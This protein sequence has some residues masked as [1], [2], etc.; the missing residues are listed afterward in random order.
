M[1]NASPNA[2]ACWLPASL[3][4]IGVGAGAGVGTVS[5]PAHAADYY[6]GKTIDIIV[7]NYPGGGYDIY[8]RTVARHLG[9]N[10]PG[11]PTI[12]VKNMPGAG[13]AK[14]GH[15]VGTVAPKD[16]LSIGAV[17]PGAI[18]GPLLDD[19]PDSIFEP[20]KVTYLGTA[21][22]GTRICATFEKS[23]T[24]TFQQAMTQKTVFGGVAAGDAIH[25]FAYMVKKTTGAAINVVAGYKGTLD[26]TLAMERGEI[27]GAC[28]WDWSSAKSQK[29]DWLRDGKL[30]LLLQIGPSANPELTKLGVPEL[31]G[32]I[33]D[34]DNRKV[35][36]TIVSQQAF[37][38]PYFIAQGTPQEY[39]TILRT[40]FD[41]TMADPQ[42]LADAQKMHID[43]SPLPGAT[44]QD[45]V[46]KFYAT[47]K[48]IVELARKSIRP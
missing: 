15:H 32:F 30:N 6:A 36:E 41:A 5:S 27:D 46:Q 35:A 38:R 23:K 22:S 33:K 45:L 18:I 28:G 2:S 19:K 13:S 7:G 12:V 9:R 14:A 8:A 44:V 21:N 39:V 42:F 40:A 31:W 4:A 34:D 16:G 25:D 1:T 10:I 26:V 11:N 43:V 47:P 37:Q 17:T 29:P 48:A 3:I 24:K 20:L